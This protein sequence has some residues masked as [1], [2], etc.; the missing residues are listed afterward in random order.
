MPRALSLFAGLLLLL[1]TA[2]GWAHPIGESNAAFVQ[3]L[4]GAA[5]GPFAYLGA[6]HMMT[7]VD[8]LLYLVGVVFF[9]RRYRDVLLYVSLF[10][11]G[12]SLT[13]VVGVLTNLPVNAFIVDALIGLSV[14]YKAFENLGG[15]GAM[16]GLSPDPRLAVLGFGLIHGLGLSTRVRDLGLAET[17]LV[18]NLLAFNAGAEVGQLLALLL[19]LTLLVG[20]RRGSDFRRQAFT[21][22]TLLMCAGFVLAGL[23]LT[24]YLLARST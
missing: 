19:V 22:N 15:F 10:T 13:L 9:L 23:H 1:A 24:G 3:G 21:A 16:S 14:A 6:R 17:D 7:G 2:Y 12:H 11:L 5:P 18:K 4:V 20:W 8:H